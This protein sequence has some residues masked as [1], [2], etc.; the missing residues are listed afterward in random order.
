MDQQ[1]QVLADGVLSS[2]RPLLAKAITLV[3]STRADHQ[4]KAHQLLSHVI[5]KTKHKQEGSF[6]VGIS[7]PPGVGKSTFIEA[8]GTFLTTKKDRKVAV[9]AVDPS[10]ARTGGSILGDKTRMEELS[11]DINAYVR[12]SPT[13]GTLGGVTRS[14]SDAIVLCEAAGYNIILVETV[15]VGQSEI[16]VEGMTDMFL[17]VANP[18]GGDELQGIKK[19][20]MESVDLVVVNKADGN[21]LPVA[22][23]S[24][25]EY[26]AA[27]R[28]VG[29]KSPHW[30]PKV[31]TCSALEKQ[32]IAEVWEVMEEYWNVMKKTGHMDIMRGNQR[33]SWMWKM[34]QDELVDRFSRNDSIQR[35]LP[36]MEDQVRTGQLTPSN[37]ADQLLA[38]FLSNSPRS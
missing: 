21:L 19:G 23:K 34:I 17:L 12:P 37:A 22:K 3:E 2:N 10:S 38:I 32:H 20:I 9:L 4:V 16:A 24:A 26:L 15:G 35:I 6:R 29:S 18:S 31:K 8:L 7:G 28:L 5:S 1:T 14:T 30:S 13:R 27:L 25:A 36:G 33:Q 11:K